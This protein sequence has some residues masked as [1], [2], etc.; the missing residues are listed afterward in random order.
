MILKCDELQQHCSVLIQALDANALAVITETLELKTEGST[1]Y[2]SITNREYFAQVKLDIGV[3][4]NFH[5]TVNAN[6]FLKL[7]SQI[8]TEAIE[9]NIMGN[10]LII[11]GNGTYKLPLIFEGEELLNLPVINIDNVTSS[12]NINSSILLSILQ[13]NSKELTKGTISKP[14]QKLYYMDE[15]GAITFTSGACVNSFSLTQPVKILLNDRI[16]KLF[17]LFKSGDVKFTLGYDAIADDIIQTKVRFETDSIIITAILSCDDTLL[18]SVPVSAIR[19]RASAEY[20]YSITV[21][22]DE[23]IQTINRLHLFAGRDSINLYSTLDFKRNSMIV[24]DNKK[25]NQEE[26]S[27]VNSEPDIDDCYTVLVDFN[28]LKKTLETCTEQY[29]TI[30][31]GNQQAI[32]ISRGSIKNVIPECMKL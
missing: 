6:L 9:L 29:L 5:A 4:E 26:I 22:K 27:Y 7:V 15:L 23:L 8:T 10:S 11:K 2:M 21:N 31:F 13:Y 16:V 25:E 28:D 3:E 19:A 30:H 14:I 18:R 12:F 32:V 17:K 20:P 24:Y 1:L